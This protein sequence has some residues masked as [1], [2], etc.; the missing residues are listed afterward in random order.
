MIG[1]IGR[2][3]GHFQITQQLGAGG[4]GVV[5]LARDLRLDRTVALKLPTD[6]RSDDAVRRR[7]RRE[8][9][10][11]SRLNHPNIAVIYDLDQ[12][13]GQDFLVMEFV[14]GRTLAEIVTGGP[15]EPAEAVRLG[16][17]LCEALVA[18][19]GEGVV[20]LDLKPRN[21]MVTGDGRLKVLDF[22]L[23]RLRARD[24][25]LTETA[26]AARPCGT[27]PYMP[28]EQLTGHY[29]DHRADLYSVGATLYELVTGQPLFQNRKGLAIYEAILSEP[30]VP[31]SH[32]NWAVSPAL[33]RVLLTALQKSPDA[34]QASAADLLND[35]RGCLDQGSV[36]RPFRL[37]RR[38]A[39]VIAGAVAATA[40]AGSVWW[41]S[42]PPT[43]FRERDWVLLGD[44]HN[45]AGDEM[46]ALTVREALSIA[47]QQSQFVN[48]VSRERVVDALRRMERFPET[49]VDEAIG[50]DLAQRNGIRVLVAGT[51]SRSGEIRRITIKT[52]DVSRNGLLFALTEELRRPEDLFDRV[53]ALA[54]RLRENLGESMSGIASTSVPLAQ[55]TTRSFD[56]LRHYSRAVEARAR[57]DYDAEEVPL[58][59][60]IVLDP[61][62]AMAHLKLAEYYLDVGG[63]GSLAIEH[64]EAAF[65]QRDRVTERE[66]HF[67]AG[68]YFAAQEQ[69]EKARDSFRIL[70][71]LYPDD[72]DFRYHLA[73][74][75]YALEEL[76]EGVAELREAVRVNP[77]SLRAVGSLV[78]FLAR[79]GKPEAA[80][81]VCKSVQREGHLAPYLEWGRGL[82][83]LGSGRPADARGAF[84]R[85]REVGSYYGLL[86]R[87]QQARV[88]LYEGRLDVVRRELNDAI[89]AIGRE[90][91]DALEIAGRLLYAR[92]LALAGDSIAARSQ[93]AAARRLTDAGAPRVVEI[94][95]T[96]TAFVEA[97]DLKNARERLEAIRRLDRANRTSL[98][99]ASSL[100]LEGQIARAEGNFAKAAEFARQSA[101]SRRWY[102]CWK[103]LAQASY[104]LKDWPGVVEAWTR[105]LR[106]SGQLLQDGVPTDL[107]LAHVGLARALDRAG[108]IE[109]AQDHVRQARAQ[110]S[111]ATTGPLKEM[112][113]SLDHLVGPQ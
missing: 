95:T 43:V 58:K 102:E 96:G 79:D 41:L 54:R 85:L 30:P 111:A 29:L 64:F 18:A 94:R 5:Y 59:S 3:L 107:G 34:R 60:A 38:A 42:S 48:V 1:M 53:D 51:I 88:S 25:A 45:Q 80:L 71:N 46:M 92:S 63:D 24:S 27:P 10:A 15:L 37:T 12:Q 50:L 62:F 40:G 76:E 31:P 4:M 52:I 17:Q 77:H 22:G 16:I 89:E 8:A 101:I 106:H 99:T 20:H 86:G 44:L 67:I 39:L 28:P 19:H 65:A 91:N 87:L 11:L 100:L 113:D 93:A 112:L 110:W 74:A 56:A 103:C 49:T 84:Q 36:G 7:F 9:Q 97:G 26:S 69:Y 109:S 33:E 105:V 81:D 35:L 68:A 23:A 72:P 108:Q 78:L 83:L 73:L 82:S 2:Q 57:G 6:A 70:T 32:L 61:D 14:R 75:H 21:L 66:R 47:L 90:S 104:E 98:T 13:D 55:V